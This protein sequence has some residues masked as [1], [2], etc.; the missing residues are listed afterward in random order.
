[1]LRR[2]VALLLAITGLAL[3]SAGS[4][5][6]AATSVTCP[7]TVQ[8]VTAEQAAALFTLAGRRLAQ[9][10]VGSPTRYPIGAIRD[11]RDYRRT[12]PTAW[13]SGFFPGELWLMYEHTR[14]QRWLTQARRWTKAVLP[15]AGFRG[16]HD[17]GFMVGIP[18]SLGA[19][20]EPSART[21]Q[22][23]AQSEAEAAST[24]AR[25]WNPRVRA[26][27]SADYGGRWGVIIDSA[28]NA[29]MLIEVGQALGGARGDRLRSIGIQHM[30]TLARDFIRPDGSTFHRM[31]YDPLT[32]RLTGP[33]YGQGLNARTSTW[34]RGQAWAIAGF[35]R[36]YALTGEEEFLEAALRTTEYWVDHVPRGCV[37]AWDL[38]VSNPRGPRD[39][40]AVAIV[41]SGLLEL[42]SA[43]DGRGQAPSG[44][45]AASQA[46]VQV[47]VA[48]TASKSPMLRE[49][50]R[51]ALGTLVS[52][53][54]TT[55][56]SRNPGILLQQTLNVP[57]DPRDGSYVWGDYYLLDALMR[58][59]REGPATTG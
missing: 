3:G 57:A 43:M 14:Q 58:D 47:D 38:D 55:A 26:L 1:V 44:S 10:A 22:S 54:W 17:L 33:I 19:V 13:T 49:Y 51:T 40:S 30:Q 34:A 56:Y 21:R 42:A 41:A 59:Q 5:R 27:Q 31:S 29:P 24:L 6:A 23:Y 39:S 52:P 50:A 25:R 32:G 18:A 48:G 35:A 7:A 9:A 8:Q 12:G 11:Q 4:A 2:Y 16:S 20:L 28:M 36:A 37:P 46:Q 45:Q 15:M 53:G